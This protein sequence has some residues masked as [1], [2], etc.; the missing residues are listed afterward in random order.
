MREEY[1]YRFKIGLVGDSGAGKSALLLRFAGNIYTESYISTIALDDFKTKTI[2]LDDKIIILEINEQPTVVDPTGYYHPNEYRCDG[3]MFVFDLTDQV[4][5]NNVKQW[6]REI[7]T[8]MCENVV[9]LLV[10]TMCDCVDRR[11]VDYETA[12]EFADALGMDYIETSAKTGVNVDEAF[13]QLVS[14]IYNRRAKP[15]TLTNSAVLSPLKKEPNKEGFFETIF[16][17]NPNKNENNVPSSA[18]FNNT[19]KVE[20]ID[21]LSHLKTT[22]LAKAQK[23]KKKTPK[24]APLLPLQLAAYE[25][26]QLLGAQYHHLLAAIQSLETAD[27]TRAFSVDQHTEAL[28]SLHT[29]LA[30]HPAEENNVQTAL[31]QLLTTALPVYHFINK[32]QRLKEIIA[33]SAAI[34][35]TIDMLHKSYWSWRYTALPYLECIY[36]LYE[37]A[38]SHFKKAKTNSKY[39]IPYHDQASLVLLGGGQYRLPL[40]SARK[41]LCVDKKGLVVKDNACGIHAVYAANGVHYKPNMNADMP[42]QPG[43]EYAVS[44]LIQLIAGNSLAAAPSTLLSVGDIAVESETEDKR[45]IC[46]LVQAG[47]TITGMCFKEVLECQI[48]LQSWHS[49]LSSEEMINLLEDAKLGFPAASAVAREYYPELIITP[50]SASSKPDEAYEQTQAQVFFDAFCRICA[51][52]EPDASLI[53]IHDISNKP[54]HN[55]AYFYRRWFDDCLH[56]KNGLS[57]LPIV[58]GILHLYPALMKE[59]QSLDILFQ[60]NHMKSIFALLPQTPLAT[61]LEIIP[62]LLTARY[63]DTEAFSALWLGLLL[64]LPC[65]AKSDNFMLQIDHDN[66]QQLQRCR[67][68]AIDNDLSLRMPFK[69]NEDQ[70]ASLEIKNTLLGIPTLMEHP[71]HPNIRKRLL[72]HSA[73]SQFFLWLCLLSRR[74]SDYCAW[75]QQGIVSEESL[76]T[77]DMPLHLPQQ[78]WDFIK[79]KWCELQALVRENPQLTHEGCVK[80]LYPLVYAA[81]QVLQR[82]SS[83]AIAMEEKLY[84][85]FER[86]GSCSLEGLIGPI[87]WTPEMALAQRDESSPILSAT[88]RCH[89]EINAID[90]D[91]I[92]TS[93]H[94][95]WIEA[96]SLLPALTLADWQGAAKTDVTLRLQP[97]LQASIARGAPFVGYRLLELGAKV[98]QT[99]ES[100]Q[101]PLHRFCL[102]YLNYSNIKT[103]QLMAEVL[104]SHHSSD[105]DVYNGRGYTPLLEWVSTLREPEELNPAQYESALMLLKAFVAH[106]VN[107][108]A[109]DGDTHETA[110]DKLTRPKTRRPTWVMI[111]IEQGAGVHAR[112]DY[113][114]ECLAH[115]P[116]LLL[117]RPHAEQSIRWL[118]SVNLSLQ[119]YR[120]LQ[121]SRNKRQSGGIIIRGVHSEDVYLPPEITAK[122]VDFNGNF[123]AEGNVEYGRRVVKRV[124]HPPVDWYVKEH[125][126]MPG[127]EYAVTTF[128]RLLLGEHT[129]PAELFRF[130]NK[131]KECYPVLISQTVS[132]DNLHTVFNSPAQ[133]YKLAALHPHLT[134][135][136]IILAMLTHPEDGKPDNYQL[137]AMPTV[138][139]EYYRI[140][141]IDN[142]H[143]FV[144]PL[145]REEASGKRVLQV[146]CVLFCLDEMRQPVHSS[147]L[148]RILGVRLHGHLQGNGSVEEGGFLDEW[149]KAL[150]QYHGQSMALFDKE[151]R[152]RLFE[153][154][155]WHTIKYCVGAGRERLPVVVSVPFRIGAI[156]ELLWRFRRMQQ[157]L[158]ERPTIT[159]I[160]L[161]KAITPSLGIRYEEAF[162]LYP[163][164]GAE[165]ASRRFRDIAE[166]YYSTAIAGRY[167]TL[168]T[169]KHALVGMGLDRKAQKELIEGNNSYTPQFARRELVRSIQEGAHIQSIVEQLLQGN[170]NEFERLSGNEAKE[171]VVNQIDFGRITLASN[172]KMADR[173]KQRWLLNLIIAANISFR[174]LKFENCAELTDSDMEKILSQSP[175]IERLIL[176]DCPNITEKTLSHIERYTQY[177][178]FN[179]GNRVLGLSS[180]STLKLTRLPQMK[181]VGLERNPLC[182][183]SVMRL[184]MSNNPQLQAVYLHCNTL[185]QFSVKNNPLL[186]TLK[187]DTPQLTHLNTTNDAKL[188]LCEVRTTQAL[189]WISQQC[190][191]LQALRDR[192][193]SALIKAARDGYIQEIEH[194]L[195]LGASLKSIDESGNTALLL[196]VLDGHIEA[197][198]YLLT[199]HGD[200]VSL[201]EKNNIG[202]TSLLLAVSHGDTAALKYLLTEH[203]DKVSLD[204]RDN[205]GSTVLHLAAM[206]RSTET[207]QALLDHGADSIQHLKDHQGFTPLRLAL[208]HNKAEHASLLL[209]H[210]RDSLD[211]SHSALTSSEELDSLMMVLNKNE[212]ITS[213]NLRGNALSEAAL[214]Y[215]ES[216]I[217]TS[218]AT[219]TIET[220]AGIFRSGLASQ[221]SI[222]PGATSANGVNPATTP[223]YFFAAAESEQ[224]VEKVES[225]SSISSTLEI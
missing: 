185:T 212:H 172:S 197:L 170:A 127:I 131:K 93:E 94:G 71:L 19:A 38:I 2:W 101:T 156:T 75:Q 182:L 193:N 173:Q 181:T 205:E 120:S 130:M 178:S 166:E 179:Q 202:Y 29:L 160:E 196:V 191:Q 195:R 140:V 122:L 43:K 177:I 37:E 217:K 151:T 139:K 128:G 165:A 59:Q 86:F 135:E 106:G 30:L 218:K 186:T 104:L 74:D 6:V 68:V 107:L 209:S 49:R 180:L 9:K 132:G 174:S 162:R 124:C 61:A 5:Y 125:P 4:G 52:A 12:K 169:S 220:D 157:I 11:V 27:K 137:M 41:L 215:L 210:V 92:P 47:L 129:A 171:R 200:K 55:Q 13:M 153:P 83:H 211:L 194:C 58:L 144:Q 148:Q 51:K 123:H 82:E 150:E 57:N 76:A 10:G 188:S 24:E 99:D 224:V 112:G 223:H 225:N 158:K 80:A 63:L 206:R 222:L 20:T 146:K 66:H 201:A 142:D 81:Y 190:P 216:K 95:P 78:V 88:A 97:W 18:S 42:I 44:S 39:L 187:I 54:P 23:K 33:I 77:I 159:H 115:L 143:A 118:E 22:I 53:D 119:W 98:N 176:S 45:T 161:L 108:E 183:V 85:I 133:H 203:G 221:P 121:I 64:A 111:L 154:S 141:G 192:N 213:V 70:Q 34:L 198:K 90:W 35:K 16:N 48:A 7:E 208:S 69:M 8:L 145:L 31:S 138:E 32:T 136:H 84:R 25:L 72:S 113:L 184:D 15:E 175:N 60:L 21:T 103:T 28:A 110:L 79:A 40:D 155:V 91:N 50:E 102:H 26:A 36:L 163:K 56:V 199:E 105:L 14:E 73:E 167:S 96:L 126:E 189:T 147:V 3:V 46:G 134:S 1:D 152:T 214:T 164:P 65:D 67:I 204:D 149:L 100:G 109:K 87:Q 89:M 117:Q 207:L 116:P 62:Q 168:T 17:R 114:T 219:L